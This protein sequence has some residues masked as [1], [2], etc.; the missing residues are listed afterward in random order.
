M[1]MLASIWALNTRTNHLSVLS[2]ETRT[3][4]DMSAGADPPLDTFGRY[5]PETARSAIAQRVFF[6]EKNPRTHPG[7]DPFEG[8]LN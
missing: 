7:R 8:G 1:K 6:S 2:V 3:V 5:A 4:R